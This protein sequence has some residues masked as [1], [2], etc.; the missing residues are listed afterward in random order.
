[1][2]KIK[3][4]RVP[5][6]LK[7]KRDIRLSLLSTS[8]M[9]EDSQVW[10]LGSAFSTT[11]LCRSLTRRMTTSFG[12]RSV[13]FNNATMV[14]WMQLGYHIGVGALVWW[15]CLLAC[16]QK[17]SLFEI[18]RTKH[19]WEIDGTHRWCYRA[20]MHCTLLGYVGFLDNMSEVQ[21]E[22]LHICC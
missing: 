6:V 17:I 11:C 16:F 10:I 9:Q 7:K 12:R 19:D 3:I 2:I 20:G 13:G 14:C 15:S 18:M 8:I 21:K 22:V 1:M 4:P 5:Y